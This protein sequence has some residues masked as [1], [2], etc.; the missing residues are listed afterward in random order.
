MDLEGDTRAGCGGAL[1]GGI[2]GGGAGGGLR[3]GLSARGSLRCSLR[4]SLSARGSAGGSHGSWTCHVA[5]DGVST[6]LGAGSGI[7]GSLGG[8]GGGATSSCGISDG[9]GA[10]FGSGG[11]LIGGGCAAVGRRVVDGE[12]GSKVVV[13]RVAVVDDLNGVLGVWLNV[14]GRDERVATGVGDVFYIY[15]WV[16]SIAPTCFFSLILI[17]S[18]ASPIAHVL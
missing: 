18:T 16:R 11:D 5:G 6:G 12:L 9:A 13:L 7:S 4:F 1:D 14:A 17:R 2:G 15:R 3:F 8:S 10:S